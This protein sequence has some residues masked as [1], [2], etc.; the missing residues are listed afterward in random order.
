[1]QDF[2]ADGAV[3]AILPRGAL[4]RLAGCLPGP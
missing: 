2:A 1:L 4:D 3:I